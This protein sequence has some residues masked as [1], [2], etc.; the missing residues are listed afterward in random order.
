MLLDKFLGPDDLRA[1]LGAG[2]TGALDSVDTA[3]IEFADKVAMDAS[4]VT[5]ADVGRLRA[6]G[7]TDAEI[8]DVV[9]AVAARCFFSTVLDGL[10]IEADARYAQL[11]AGLRDVLTVGR[12][13]AER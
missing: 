2:E 13:I 1:V 10:G 8:L 5:D 11:D 4:S 9:L 3:I 7:L 12:P 6:L